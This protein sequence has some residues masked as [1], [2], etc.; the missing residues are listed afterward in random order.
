MPRREP[1]DTKAQSQRRWAKKEAK[2]RL[3]LEDTV[4]L[5]Q[6]YKTLHYGLKRNHERSVAIVHPLMF[7]TRRVIYAAVIVFLGD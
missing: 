2:L 5:S 3:K 4:Q 6:K 7:L 1:F